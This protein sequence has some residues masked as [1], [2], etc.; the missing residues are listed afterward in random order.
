MN[1]NALVVNSSGNCDGTEGMAV[2]KDA[3][4]Q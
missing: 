3:M 2:V 4:V 1:E